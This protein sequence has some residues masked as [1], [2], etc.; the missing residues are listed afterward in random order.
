MSEQGYDSADVA[1]EEEAAIQGSAVTAVTDRGKLAKTLYFL[2]HLPWF[3][4]LLVVYVIMQLAVSDPR[5]VLFT[6]GYYSLTWVEVLYV[7]AAMVG[8]VEQIKVSEPGVN[9]TGDALGMLS[10]GVVYLVLFVLGTAG[11]QGFR[12]FN[13]TEFLVLLL[14]AA[15]QIVMAFLINGRT[16][17]RAIGYV[18]Q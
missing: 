13:N 2:G 3:L 8:M 12:L 16:L 9:N 7:A 1:G 14:I 6:V 11:I 10:A 4:I 15:V 18:P 17:K 5:A